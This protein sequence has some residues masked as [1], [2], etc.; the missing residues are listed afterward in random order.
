M[1]YTDIVR[2][3][4]ASSTLAQMPPQR[5]PAEGHLLSPDLLVTLAG[6]RR[7]RVE[8]RQVNLYLAVGERRT[9]Q[10]AVTAGQALH[11]SDVVTKLLEDWLPSR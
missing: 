5:P 9:L 8:G 2:A 11:L 10:A 4:W 7:R 1:T 6:T 3:A